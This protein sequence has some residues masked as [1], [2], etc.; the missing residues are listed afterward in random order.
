MRKL[1]DIQILVTI[2]KFLL[3]YS[4]TNSFIYCH[5]CFH[6]CTTEQ[7]S[8]HTIRPA[9]S[10]IF[11]LQPFTEKVC[12]PLVYITIPIPQ[13]DHNNPLLKILQFFPILF[14]VRSVKSLEDTD[15]VLPANPFSYYSP[16]CSVCP[17]HSYPVP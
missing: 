8:R 4:H 10:K 14:T 2:N 9:K 13:S 12:Q 7:Y 5:G 1:Q 6:T 17:S 3:N 11:T 16:L 15:I